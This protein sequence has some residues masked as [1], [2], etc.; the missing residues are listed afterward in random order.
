MVDTES[1]TIILVSLPADAIKSQTT[2]ERSLQSRQTIHSIRTYTLSALLN[3][4]FHRSAHR[5][6]DLFGRMRQIRDKVD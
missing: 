6:L 3:H 4:V 1:K 5:C 2:P